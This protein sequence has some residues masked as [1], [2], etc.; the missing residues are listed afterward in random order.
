MSSALMLICW[1]TRPGKITAFAHTQDI[2]HLADSKIGLFLFD[3]PKHH[4]L[5][6]TKK[7]VAFFRMSHSS[8]N[9]LFSLLSRASSMSLSSWDPDISPSCLR[10]ALHLPKVESPM[11]RSSATYFSESLLVKVMRT[12]L[13]LNSSVLLIPICSTCKWHFNKR[14]SLFYRYQSKNFKTL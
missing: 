1:A 7:A 11:P 13:F 9:I 14:N 12:A 2:A 6:L 3:K 10:A 8:R 5:W 4:R